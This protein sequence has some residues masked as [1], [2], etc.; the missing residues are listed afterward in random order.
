VSSVASRDMAAG[1]SALS[2]MDVLARE[3]MPPSAMDQS[4][5]ARRF[6]PE[7][8]D[9]SRHTGAMFAGTAV[10]TPKHTEI[11]F[12][13]AMASCYRRYSMGAAGIVVIT[14]HGPN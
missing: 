11:L 7:H 5:H 13:G 8:F 6:K 1:L 10:S 14:S 4:Q 12:G 9:D 3:P 2:A